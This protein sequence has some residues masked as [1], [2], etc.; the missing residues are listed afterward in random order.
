MIDVSLL[1]PG[2]LGIDSV[3]IILETFFVREGALG[4]PFIGSGCPDWLRLCVL[5][6]T[7]EILPGLGVERGVF[8]SLACEFSG[9]VK[10]L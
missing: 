4:I 1:R 6:L 3:C 9:I 5:D 8:T 2:G 7:G 10:F